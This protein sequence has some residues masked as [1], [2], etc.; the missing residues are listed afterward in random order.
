MKSRVRR[1]FEF[2]RDHVRAHAED[3]Q[4]SDTAG[5]NIEI[6]FQREI[7]APP[8]AEVYEFSDEGQLIPTGTQD[9]TQHIIA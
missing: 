3:W 1:S 6:S 8:K 5:A 7:V 9:N 4:I 2:H